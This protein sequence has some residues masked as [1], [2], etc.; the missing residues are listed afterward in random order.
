MEEEE[1]ELWYAEQK[2]KLSEEFIRCIDR[3]MSVERREAK[4]NAAFERLHKRY[5]N[6][7][8]AFLRRND[9]QKRKKQRKARILAPFIAVGRA[10]STSTTW[11]FG[12]VAAMCRARFGQAS[13][14]VRIFWLRN[15]HK[16]V[17][18]TGNLFRPLYYLYARKMKYPLII[19]TKPLVIVAGWV[20]RLFLSIKEDIK[21]ASS[22]SWKAALKAAKWTFK[23]SGAVANSISGKMDAFTKRYNEWQSKRVQAHLDKKQ[24]R[25]EAK[26][27]R[28]EEKEAKRKEKDGNTGEETVK[29]VESQDT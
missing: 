21:K 4:F 12:G 6:K 13:F 20:K 14:T 25:E 5:E 22:A 7:Y 18:G 9:A 28:K 3:G 19:I 17:D 11:M 2:Q 10:L 15:G 16:M 1:I 26:K 24:A 27:K 29:E 23:H 8:S